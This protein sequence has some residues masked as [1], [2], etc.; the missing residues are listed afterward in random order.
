MARTPTPA[1]SGPRPTAKGGSG[2]KATPT[3]AP[4]PTP[5]SA[6]YPPLGSPAYLQVLA[7]RLAAMGIAPTDQR[8]IGFMSAA[9]AGAAILT[10]LDGQQGGGAG[11]AAIPGMPQATAD[12]HLMYQGRDITMAQLFKEFHSM[13]QQQMNLIGMRLYLAGQ[14]PT[15]NADQMAIWAAFQRV[16]EMASYQY[17]A[18]GNK[19]ADFED[20]MKS[21]AK[22][23][24]M[25]GADKTGGGD[26]DL[27]PTRTETREDP[28][29]SNP[30]EAARF[31][32]EALK[33]KLGRAPTKAEK[34]TWLAALNAE[35]G[36]N[37]VTTSTVYSD[38]NQ[39]TG[40]YEHAKT[41][42]SGGV[43]NAQFADD[44]AKSHNEKEYKSY[45]A[46]TTYWSAM[47]AGLAAP[48]DVG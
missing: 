24:A 32:D 42:H 30:T 44:Y 8:Y 13:N 3:P 26:K 2:T 19:A 48:T 12:A 16:G 14:I 29:L 27:P 43:D 35:Q 10:Y 23:W 37:P 22:G 4:A 6:S 41:T 40:T 45:Q 15:P 47:M 20:I 25:G 1:P 31:L 7:A 18:T 5:S 39:D 9:K 21:M 28:N 34:A 17:A 36:S 11:G 38:P 46:A 33:N